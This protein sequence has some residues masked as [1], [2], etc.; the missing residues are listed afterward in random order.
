MAKK[1]ITAT[2]LTIFAVDYSSVTREVSLDCEVDE[3]VTTDYESGGWEEKIGGIKRYTLN[4]TVDHDE[5]L[6]GLD[7][8]LWDNFGSTT[9]FQVEV[10]GG[11]ATSA[12][13]PKFTGTVL[14]NKYRWGAPVGSPNSQNFSFPGAGGPLVRAEA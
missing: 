8:D 14:V 2:D 5:D 1:V 9:A 6:S 10:D 4:F 11:S 12:S 7:E 3:H 13:N